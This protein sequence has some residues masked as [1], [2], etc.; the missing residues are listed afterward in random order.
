MNELS[1]TIYE[2]L[3]KAEKNFGPQEAFRYKV[4]SAG[5]S[6]KKETKVEAKTYTQLRSDSEH[7]GAA[8]IMERSA[9]A[10]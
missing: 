3:V 10:A 7:F 6:G 5:E 4:K 9:A 2:L 1:S 8:H